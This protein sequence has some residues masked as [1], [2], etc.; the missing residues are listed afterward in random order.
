MSVPAHGADHRTR[1]LR[2]EWMK[3]PDAMA[4]RPENAQ[5]SK[6][7][8]GETSPLETPGHGQPALRLDYKVTLL[9]P[10]TNRLPIV[11]LMAFTR[12]TSAL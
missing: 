4:A 5:G 8:A 9:M 7:C 3:T 12:F 2:I 10:P 1:C 11:P 6:L